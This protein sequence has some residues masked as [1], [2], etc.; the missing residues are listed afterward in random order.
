M[1]LEL[2]HIPQ[3]GPCRGD[4]APTT[5]MAFKSHT[6]VSKGWRSWCQRVLTYPPFMDILQKVHL[7]H[8]V[9]VFASLVIRKDSKNLLSLLYR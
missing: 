2:K 9:L 6:F 5:D 3:L 8:T 4:F 1:D 7:V